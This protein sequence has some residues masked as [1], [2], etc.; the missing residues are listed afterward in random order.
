MV[1]P[2]HIR[3]TALAFQIASDRCF[4]ERPLS[5]GLNQKPVVPA[6]VCTAFG[7]EL[8]LKAIIAFETGTVDSR[9]H[10]LHQ[11]FIKLTPKSKSALALAMDLG[12]DVIRQKLMAHSKVFVEWR[13]I[14]ESSSA[15]VEYEFLRYLLKA[16]TSYLESF[17]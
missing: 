11:L 13:Y 9:K 10:E 16:A 12:E 5:N 17:G 14:Y 7:I 4:E 6:I 3:N 1:D 2:K 8:S 15:S